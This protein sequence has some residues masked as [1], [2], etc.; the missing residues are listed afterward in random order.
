VCG[1]EYDLGG[2]E[3][4]VSDTH[5]E[6]L[7]FLDS[8]FLAMEDRNA[9][10]H[11]AGVMKFAPGGLR[12]ADGSVDVDRIKA[13]IESKLHRIPRYRQVLDWIPLEEHPVWIDDAFFDIDYHVRRATL[14]EE[15][16]DAE[17]QRLTGTIFSQKLDRFRPLWEVWVVDGFTDD[18]LAMITKV[19]HCMID[20]MAGVD[21]MKELLAP[22][23]VTEIPPAPPYEPRPSPSKAEL[24][25]DEAR[26]RAGL[27]FQALR[28]FRHLSDSITG[29]VGEVDT[30]LRAMGKALGAGWLKNASKTPLNAR[31]GP[32]REFKWMKIDLGDAKSV[33][34]AFGGTINDVVLTTVA[35]AVRKYF[36][37]HD[38]AV[39][40]LDFRVMAPVSVRSDGDQS[41]GNRVAMWLLDLPIA[42]Q[43]P[44]Q[45][46]NQI[47]A[48]TAE[49][50]ESNQALGASLLV[51]A[52]SWTPSTILTSAMRLTGTSV[53]PFNMTVTNV[54]GP[55]IPIYFLDALLEVQYPMVPLW[56]NHGVGIALFSYKGE[57]AWGVVADSD[58]VTD[59]DRFMDCLDEAFREL[60]HAARPK[61]SR[62]PRAKTAAEP[63]A[64]PAAAAKPAA[65]TTRTAKPA[66]TK[67][68]AKTTNAKQTALGGEKNTAIGR[69]AAAGKKATT[70]KP[71]P[72]PTPT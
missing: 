28:S 18:S 41:L 47:A 63:K 53:R 10:F 12:A 51:Q 71:A 34:N 70:R 1:A 32:N 65:K 26:R 49:L 7:S 19:H 24:L 25:A 20:G 52:T 42:L 60:V 29:L 37:A 11:V 48:E 46:F 56:T 30:R 44:R 38:V 14:T 69:A 5:Y 6:R 22:F 9:H 43:T 40:Q 13:H 35:G 33:K 45:R 59:L 58:S 3:E 62:K 64:K 66:A 4:T 61:T 31:I 8:T 68:A 2:P 17:L 36:L 67:P 72:K 54:P 15:R 27:P 39:D 21:L 50:K 57:I 23:P 16:D 55:Q